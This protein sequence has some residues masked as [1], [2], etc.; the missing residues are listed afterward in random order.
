MHSHPQVFGSMNNLI[1]E[2][3]VLLTGTPIQNN[4]GELW[5]LLHFIDPANFD[6]LD[7]FVALFGTMS[8]SSQ[9]VAFAWAHTR[10]TCDTR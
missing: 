7:Q 3:R 6:D 4:I 2:H 10:I 9:V 8:D 5:T 1:T